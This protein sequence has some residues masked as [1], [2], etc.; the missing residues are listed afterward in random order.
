MASMRLSWSGVCFF[1]PETLLMKSSMESS[2]ILVVFFGV[3]LPPTPDL[4]SKRHH[5][6]EDDHGK[7]EVV[8]EI[9]LLDGWNNDLVVR[10]VG[11]RGVGVLHQEVVRAR[12]PLHGI[13]V[14][15]AIALAHE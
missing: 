9:A 14:Q 7:A 15:N 11:R 5:E 3:D 6:C 4:V 13:D 2:S 1:P 12:E 10:D 8:K